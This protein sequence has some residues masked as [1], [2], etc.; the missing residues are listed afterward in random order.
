MNYFIVMLATGFG[1]GYSP[2]AP[3]TTGT[4]LSIPIYLFLSQ[5]PSPL[6]E[7]TLLTFF[8]LASWIS[9]QA[10]KYWAT[11]DDQRIVIDEMMGFLITM[12]WIPRT[13]FFISMGFILFRFFDILKPFPIRRLEKR[14][15]GGF[16]VVLDDV[17]A[18][19]YV[20]IILQIISYY[21]TLSPGVRGMG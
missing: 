17:A 5:I 16:G 20:N 11:K 6:Y 4:L 19:V 1:V 12:L 13:I 3:G 9:E 2:I 15:K 10:Q 8:F 14:W 18:G 7:L 21:F